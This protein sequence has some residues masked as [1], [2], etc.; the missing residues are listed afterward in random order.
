MTDDLRSPWRQFIEQDPVDAA[1]SIERL[2][3]EQLVALG[4]AP[5]LIAHSGQLPPG[6][7]WTTWLILA[8]RGFGKTWAGAAWVDACARSVKG[9]R[10]ALVGATLNDARA[11]MVEGDAGVLA[12]A[13]RRPKFEPARR[14]L[15][16]KNGSTA[17]LFGAAEP[18]S[19]RGPSFHFAWG[20][21]AAKWD[22]AADALSNLRLALRLGASPRLLLTTTPRPLPWLKTMAAGTPGVVVT[23]GRTVDNRANLAPSFLDGVMR[24]YGGTR[25]GRQELQGEIIDDLDGALWTRGGIE[26]CRVGIVPRLTRT[27]IAVDPP[28]SQTGDA[29]GIVVVALGAD[30]HG[31][32]I[33]DRSVE[34]AAP[35]VWARAVVAAADDFTADLIVAEVNNGGEMVASVL[36]MVDKTLP[37]KPVHAARGK[38]A[39]AE[40]V[41]VL[42][43]QGKVHHAGAFPELEDELCGLM[44]GGGYA[45][46]G[47]SPDRADALVWAVSE[48]LLGKSPRMPSV[49][50]L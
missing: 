8:G 22:R 24:D 3:I 17:S 44:T 10:I 7:D 36:R 46:P 13:R 15:T 45:G 5:H 11:V 33:A 50:S 32:V 23:R 4:S 20:D 43:V 35:E 12:V 21:E 31:Y 34:H 26:A 37:I 48:L 1:K 19:L 27:V 40:P 47:R 30:G 2:P 41:S 49:R 42:Y 38:V 28:A 29:C 39:R 25:L 6:G 14:L 9:A 16:W 18:D